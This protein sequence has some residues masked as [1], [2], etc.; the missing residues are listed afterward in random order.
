VE[1]A[2]PIVELTKHRLA[3][4]SVASAELIAGGD[5]GL[6]PGHSVG[7]PAIKLVL[8]LGD[9]QHRAIDCG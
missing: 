1:V 2:Q 5:A 3:P 6:V 7:R 8:L 4:E 9:E